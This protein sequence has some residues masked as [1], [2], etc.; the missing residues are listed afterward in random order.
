VQNYFLFSFST[1]WSISITQ[2]GKSDKRTIILHLDVYGLGFC[3]LAVFKLHYDSFVWI[4]D[5]DAN[6][7]NGFSRKIVLVKIN[8]K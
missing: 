7:S 8:K 5:K 2:N 3:T 1:S 6:C 4:S